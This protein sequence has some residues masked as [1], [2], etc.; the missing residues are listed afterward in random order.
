VIAQAGIRAESASDAPKQ[1]C[2]LPAVP[3]PEV[4]CNVIARQ[5]D[6]IRIE[7]INA[8]DAAAQVLAANGAAVVKVADMRYSRAVQPVTAAAQVQVDFNH[9]E[10]L[11][12]EQFGI[13]RRA[14]AEAERPKSG[15]SEVQASIN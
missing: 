4:V 3:A 9:F 12:R 10:P 11:R 5:H 14:G 2:N 8:L 15:A 1:G 6:Y 13:D 7:L